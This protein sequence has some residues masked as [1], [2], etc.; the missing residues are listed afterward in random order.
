MNWSARAFGTAY[1]GSACLVLAVQEF[2][3]REG[4]HCRKM[5]PH[6]QLADA[7]IVEREDGGNEAESRL[8]CRRALAGGTKRVFVIDRAHFD[9]AIPDTE[10]AKQTAE[11]E[12]KARRDKLAESGVIIDDPEFDQLMN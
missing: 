10:I 3:A 1:R 7:G 6:K 9:E 2:N 8:T 11:Q 4:G 5:D 12:G